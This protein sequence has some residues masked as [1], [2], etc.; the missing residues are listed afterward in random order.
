MVNQEDTKIVQAAGQIGRYTLLSRVT[1]LIRDVVIGSLFGASAATDAFF[2]AFR[3]PNLLRRLVGEGATNAAIIPVV[4]HYLV[5][6]SAA[7]TQDM[8]RVLLGV[9]SGLLLLLTAAG[10]V[11]AAPLVNLFAP[12]F[13][14]ETFRLTVELTHITFVYVFCIGL[15]ALATGILNAQRHFVAPA[16]SPVLLNLAIIGCAVGVSGWLTR[17]IFSLAYGVA[18]GGVCQVGWQIPTLRRLGISLLPRWQPRHPAIQQIGGLLFPVIF[19]AAVYQL[20]LLVNTVLASLLQVGSVSALWYASRV[21]EF[22]QGIVV[23]AFASAALPSLA[24]HVQQKDF[25]SVS[26]SLGLALRLINIV[27]LPASIGLVILAVPVSS[28]LFFRGA[29]GADQIATAAA[30]LQALA[31]G[32]WSVA[33]SRLLT[34]CLHAMG[35]TRTPVYTGIVTFGVN[36][37]LSLMLMGQISLQPGANSLAQLLA[38]LSALLAVYDFGVVGL[39]VAASLGTTV[40]MILLA[41]VLSPRLPQFP[42]SAWLR[43]LGWSLF[44]SALMAGPVWGIAGLINWIDPLLSTFVRLGVLFLAIGVGVTSVGLV[45]RWGGKSELRALRHLLPQ[46]LLRRLPQFF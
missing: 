12:G 30:V 28:T 9:A 31:L 5:H 25:V 38:E 24:T 1:G 42:W 34:S 16:F 33:S 32:L 45:L 10:I 8:I 29:F 15:L 19:G 7:E 20:S 39:A 23:S 14:P 44:A 22:P 36:A 6:R 18:L 11:F 41:F 4:T 46:R 21:F 43:S 26:T 35:D 40:N 13:A 37:C 2:V 27:V 3:I 17:P